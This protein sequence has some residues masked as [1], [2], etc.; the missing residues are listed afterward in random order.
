MPAYSYHI[1]SKLGHVSQAG[2]LLNSHGVGDEYM[3]ILGSYALVYC[4]GGSGR[5]I[6]GTRYITPFGAGDLMILFPQEPH[7]YVPDLPRGMDQHYL[8]FKGCVFDLW[9]ELNLISPDRPLFR[10]EPVAYWSDRFAELVNHPRPLTRDQALRHVVLVQQLLADIANRR[11]KYPA[12]EDAWLDQ[13]RRLFSHG[14]RPPDAQEVARK[15]G[16]SYEHFRKEFRRRTGESPAQYRAAAVMN[17]AAELMMAEGLSNQEVAERLG[18]CDEF[19]FSKR[20]RAL[21]G[22]SPRQFRRSLP[23]QGSG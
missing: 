14:D 6:E 21:R 13:A 20:F 5:F 7:A 1:P 12:R 22:L 18:F 9:L 4:T 8:V 15:V 2:T 3:R 19:H 16:M 11:E 10:M 17:R 23:G